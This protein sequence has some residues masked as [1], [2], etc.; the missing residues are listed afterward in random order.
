[1]YASPRD[2]TPNRLVHHHQPHQQALRPGLAKPA[3]T[4]LPTTPHS[5]YLS[6]LT[7][8]ALLTPTQPIHELSRRQYK[9]HLTTTSPHYRATAPPTS[10]DPTQ[11]NSNQNQIR[12]HPPPN[13]RHI[14]AAPRRAAPR[15]A[16]ICWPGLYLLYSK[17]L[18]SYSL[19]IHHPP[20][21]VHSAVV[22]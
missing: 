22:T 21:T 12:A 2:A 14:Y 18:I 3:D 5:H 19:P 11:P 9:K 10:H 15:G 6:C 17:V 20:S 13:P 16:V 7:I 4:Q 1:M 8:S